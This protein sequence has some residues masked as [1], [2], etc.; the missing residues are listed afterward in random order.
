MPY[1]C[2]MAQRHGFTLDG[3]AQMGKEVVLYN[4]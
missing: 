3:C 1:A 4:K 2:T